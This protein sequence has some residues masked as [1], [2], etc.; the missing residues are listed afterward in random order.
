MTFFKTLKYGAMLPI[1]TG[2]AACAPVT[3]LN[4]ITT[5]K[6]FTVEKN[7][8]YGAL[9]SQ[10]LDIYTPANPVANAPVVVFFYGGGWNDGSKDIY[11]FI[12]QSFTEARYTVIVPDYRL[13]PDVIYPEFLKDAAK[14][15]AFTRA[16]YDRPMVLAGHSAGAHLASMVA[17]D[18]RYLAAEG[19][20]PCAVISGWAGLAGPYDF[21][22]YEEP[23]LSIFPENLRS[24]MRPINYAADSKIPALMITGDD[25]TTVDPAQTTRMAA[26]LSSGGT[27][28][29]TVF[30][31]GA[32]HID[33]L[34]A[35]S[36]VLRKKDNPVRP[37]MMDF[38]SAHDRASCTAN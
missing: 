27:E 21:K 16:R 8:A 22:V 33:V 31:E 18:P 24:E 4:G 1:L 7:V 37:A 6:N 10:K 15:V 12:G 29:K 11:K 5:D 2:L 14:A 3:V 38:V 19:L 36:T 25:D 23:Y 30:I 20:T 26:A 28:A 32:G 9:P 13:Y 35:M 34:T 17:V